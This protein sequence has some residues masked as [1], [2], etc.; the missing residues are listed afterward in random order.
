M[1][2]NEG[3]N[4]ELIHNTISNLSSI[5]YQVYTTPSSQQLAIVGPIIT[6]LL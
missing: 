4:T 3:I 5:M 6:S 2:M 1:H